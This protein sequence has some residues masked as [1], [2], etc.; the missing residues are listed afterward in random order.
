M[1]T[2]RCLCG[3]FEIEARGAPRT[4]AFCHCSACRHAFGTVAHMVAV[5]QPQQVTVVKGDLE[6]QAIWI[7]AVDSNSADHMGHTSHNRARR[8]RCKGCG[9]MLGAWGGI[10]SAAE[11]PNARFVSLPTM[12]L[13]PLGDQ[14]KIAAEL[15][16]VPRPRSAFRHVPSTRTRGHGMHL[17]RGGHPARALVTS[18]LA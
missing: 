1:P 5:Y 6:T 12:L 18:P 11:T 7:K 10:K 14:V 3:T 15:R 16:P 9:A 4:T 2:G 13:T 8:Y 17:P